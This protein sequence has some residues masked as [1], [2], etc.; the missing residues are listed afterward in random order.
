MR[1]IRF[2]QVPTTLLAHDSAVGGKVA[3]NH[4]LGKNMIGAFHQP[5]AVVYHTPFLQ[6]LPEKRV[7][8]RL[9]RSDKTCSNW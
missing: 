8:L 5:E 3:I 1:G 4:P 6:S 2:V 9:C 7:A